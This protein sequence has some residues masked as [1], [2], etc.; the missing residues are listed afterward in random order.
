M[1]LCRVAL[2]RD[3]QRRVAL[4]V[5]GKLSRSTFVPEPLT[6]GETLERTVPPILS[7]RST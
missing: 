4:G 7:T 2:Q 3:P 5:D 1:E 6:V